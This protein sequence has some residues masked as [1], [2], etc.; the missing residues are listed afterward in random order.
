MS[1]TAMPELPEHRVNDEVTPFIWHGYTSPNS[2]SLRW[3]KPTHWDFV[4]RV[5]TLFTAKHMHSYAR[6]YAASIEA[7]RDAMRA[8]LADI[9]RMAKDCRTEQCFLSIDAVM[10]QVCAALTLTTK[11]PKP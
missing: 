11:E 10:A 5:E 3:T 9:G 2:R 4:K 7:E 1:D 8:A 6:Q